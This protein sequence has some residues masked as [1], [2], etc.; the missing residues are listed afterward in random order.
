MDIK[1]S[2]VDNDI[3]TEN[4]T[5]SL[6]ESSEAT[7][8][9]LRI[10]LKTFLGEW[11]LDTRIGMPYFQEFF[12]KK[13]NKLVMDS[14]IREAVEEDEG[15]ESLNSINYDFD[16]TTRALSFSFTATLVSGETIILN[17]NDF[18]IGD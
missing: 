16:A 5:L 4:N 15:I 17:F 8:Q 6:V 7:A 1:L 18:V 13:P 9:R 11:F 10:K 12:V 14:R 3:D 2:T